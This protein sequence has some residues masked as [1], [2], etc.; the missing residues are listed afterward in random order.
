MLINSGSNHYKETR[1]SHL[2]AGFLSREKTR[3][4]LLFFCDHNYFDIGHDVGV[5][6]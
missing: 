3:A 2:K 5:K 6:L 4:K 1:Q